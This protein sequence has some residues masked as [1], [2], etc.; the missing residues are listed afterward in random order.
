MAVMSIHKD[1][2]A[3]GNQASGK[4]VVHGCIYEVK[5][6]SNSDD[7]CFF[8]RTGNGEETFVLTM[9]SQDIANA[10][11]GRVVDYLSA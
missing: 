4:S 7:I 11:T 8:V 2:T 1:V 3:S 10:V 6:I 5:P 9:S